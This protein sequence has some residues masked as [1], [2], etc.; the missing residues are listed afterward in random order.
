[1]AIAERDDLRP[2]WPGTFKVGD[3][4]RVRL[5]GECPFMRGEGEIVHAPEEDGVTGTVDRVTCP[6]T[7][8]HPID[9][10]FDTSYRLNGQTWVGGCFAA[11]ELE[12]LGGAG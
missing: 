1:M 4:V 2:Y 7:P 11:A 9:V 5:S 8:G 3:R 10:I 12:P 6:F